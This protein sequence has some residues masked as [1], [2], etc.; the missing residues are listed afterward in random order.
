MSD[1]EDIMEN[2]RAKGPILDRR[3]TR[4]KDGKGSVAKTIRHSVQKELN[5]QYKARKKACIEAEALRRAEIVVNEKVARGEFLR[6]YKRD[7]L[8][9]QREFVRE[10]K[11]SEW[12]PEGGF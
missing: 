3:S 1:L 5:A 8:H 6:V 10:L 7:I 4:W 11:H 2:W 12:E 9:Y